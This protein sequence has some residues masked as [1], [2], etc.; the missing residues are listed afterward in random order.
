MTRKMFRDAV[1]VAF[2]MLTIRAHILD[3][4]QEPG[5]PTPLDD[6]GP[7]LHQTQLCVVPRQASLLQKK[8]TTRYQFA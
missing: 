4:W 3:M 5:D 7:V 6:T 8:W 2:D 1:R